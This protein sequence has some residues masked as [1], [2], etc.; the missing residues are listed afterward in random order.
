MAKLAKFTMGGI[1]KFF[2]ISTHGCFSNSTTATEKNKTFR[3]ARKPN[4]WVTRIKVDG[5]L[6]NGNIIRCDFAFVLED[7]QSI[8]FVELKS[9]DINHA[10]DQIVNTIAFF[11]S[12]M[13]LD[14]QQIE[15]CIVSSSVPRHANLKFQSLV[16]KFKKEHGT[17]LSKH[18]NQCIRGI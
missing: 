2:H 16:A 5:C 18:T 11:K 14:K 17:S 3:I 15:G 13:L 8:I 9:E 12:F 10:Y 1:D 7:K 4:D 6:I